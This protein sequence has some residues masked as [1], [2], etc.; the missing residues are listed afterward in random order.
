MVK[1]PT[2]NNR[3]AYHLGDSIGLEVASWEFWQWLDLFLGE[4][5]YLTPYNTIQI[6]DLI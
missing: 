5:K 3:H 1:D 4:D 6:A 2:I